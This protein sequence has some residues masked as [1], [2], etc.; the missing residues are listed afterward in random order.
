MN[1]WFKRHLLLT[2]EERLVVVGILLI[3]LTGLVIKYFR[4]TAGH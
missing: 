4:N 2:R 3:A 1:D